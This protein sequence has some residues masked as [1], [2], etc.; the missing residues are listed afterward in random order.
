MVPRCGQQQ[1]QRQTLWLPSCAAAHAESSGPSN[2]SACSPS[3]LPLLS[4]SLKLQLLSHV[5]NGDGAHGVIV[6]PG[7]KGSKYP[8]KRPV[9]ELSTAHCRE[10]AAC[11]D[12]CDEITLITEL[13]LSAVPASSRI[14]LKPASTLRQQHSPWPACMQPRQATAYEVGPGRN[15][16]A[17]ELT[18][19]P[20]EE[21]WST[22]GRLLRQAFRAFVDR[23]K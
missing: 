23:S 16:L 19:L 6:C 15:N 8:S 22:V 1:P 10:H 12:L 13:A 21:V 18:S 14:C 20:L 11:C 9:G 4:G 17:L 3:A 7:H 2:A 5:F